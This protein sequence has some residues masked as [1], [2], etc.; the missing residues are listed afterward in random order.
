MGLIPVEVVPI[1]LDI[2][3]FYET[4]EQQ[5]SSSRDRNDIPQHAQ[6]VYRVRTAS[7]KRANKSKSVDALRIEPR[8]ERIGI[9]EIKR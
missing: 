9:G 1:E 4:Q 8:N 5:R 7:T 6:L 3:N 2:A